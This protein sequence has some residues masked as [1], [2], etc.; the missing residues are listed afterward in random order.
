M[1]IRAW[2]SLAVL[3]VMG[4][5]DREPAPPAAPEAPKL[6]DASVQSPAPP[7][8]APQPVPVGAEGSSL[9]VEL[10]GQPRRFVAR[11]AGHATINRLSTPPTI[12]VFA[13]AEGGE[14]LVLKIG[15]VDLDRVALPLELRA[16]DVG[17]P[18]VSFTYVDAE[19]RRYTAQVDR[20]A[21]TTW[22]TLDAWSPADARLS[23][24][25]A[26]QLQASTGAHV[27]SNGAF[28][29]VLHDPFVAP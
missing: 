4:C 26:A 25:F 21:P 23:G 6:A 17:G 16:L 27:L 15:G 2:C 7:H 12:A 8:G 13:H 19:G 10:D 14:K 20:Q 24:R 9:V 18:S 28:E 5:G 11:E 3:V 29:V 1:R 22:V